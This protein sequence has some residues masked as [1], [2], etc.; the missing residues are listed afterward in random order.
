MSKIGDAKSDRSVG[1]SWCWI[2]VKQP[3]TSSSNQNFLKVI[4][5]DWNRS[6]IPMHCQFFRV[7]FLCQCPHNSKIRQTKL[8]SWLQE[9][10]WPFY[11]IENCGNLE[12]A[13]PFITAN[14]ADR[15]CFVYTWRS[16]GDLET[17]YLSLMSIMTK[18][19]KGRLPL[20]NIL[21][22]GHRHELHVH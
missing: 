7:V 6:S 10:M 22:S 15:N 16:L 18:V 19:S 2:Q 3:P 12:L 17:V 13:F 4:F 1:L 14:W 8:L 9:I 20:F 11:W 21:Y 5:L